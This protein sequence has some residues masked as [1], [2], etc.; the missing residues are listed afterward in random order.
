MGVP[1]FME[2][3]IYHYLFG[4]QIPHF[5]ISDLLSSSTSGA[6]LPVALVELPIS[7]GGVAPGLVCVDSMNQMNVPS[8][9]MLYIY[10]LLLNVHMII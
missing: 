9:C 1:P 7:T 5:P 6:W 10:I 8:K 4:S 3:P 2:T